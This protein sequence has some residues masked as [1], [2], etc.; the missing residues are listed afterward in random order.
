MESE[1]YIKEKELTNMPKAISLEALKYLIP[2]TE[3][4][5]RKIECTDGR[6]GTG[7]FC[8][9]PDNWNIMKVLMTNNHVLRK[10]DIEIG[11][12]IEFSVNNEETHYQIEINESRKIFTDEKYEVTIIELKQNDK[13]NK[14]EFFDIDKEIFK[15]ESIKK[16]R[17]KQIYLLHYSKGNKLEY[18]IGLIKSINEDNYTI[19]H[20][21][22]SSDGSSGGPLINSINFQVI[23]IHNRESEKGNY[24]LGTLLKEPIEIFNNKIENNKNNENNKNENINNDENKNKRNNDELINEDIDEIIMQYKIDDYDIKIS[25]ETK[26]FGEMFVKNNKDKCKIIND[27]NEIELISQLIITKNQLKD[28][29]IF[30]IKLKGIKQ[31]TDISFMFSDCNK[32]SSLSDISKWNTSNIT[33]MS[34]LFNFCESLSSLPDISNWNT[35]KV[36]GMSS[37][38]SCCKSLPDISK[39]DTSNVTDMSNMF[40]HCELISSIPDIS[41]WDTSKVTNMG[42]MFFDCKSISSLP[43]ISKWNTSNVINMCGMFGNCKSLSSLPDISKWN[44]SNLTRTSDMFSNCESLSSLPDISKWNTSNIYNMD[45]MFKGCKQLKKIPKKFK[46]GCFII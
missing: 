10:E 25:N 22:D 9:I 14:I 17:N 11:K 42:G 44:T 29:N 12:K 36:T 2:K 35:S 33:N 21:C 24:N 13:L 27:G 31:I 38:F 7:F 6:H 8:N 37:M 46:K 1:N 23:G 19:R 41:N 3:T 15:D 43:D 5:I 28:N 34:Y 16:F 39:W 32:L 26:L 45:D 30:E 20:L 18:S 4:C 40:S